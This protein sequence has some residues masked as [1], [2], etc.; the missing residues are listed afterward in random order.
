MNHSIKVFKNKNLFSKA[1]QNILQDC[2][3]AYLFV[4]FMTVFLKEEL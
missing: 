3:C 2:R 1:V 4:L